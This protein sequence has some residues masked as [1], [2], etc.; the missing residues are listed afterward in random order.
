MPWLFS[1]RKILRPLAG[2]SE[3]FT[4][5][6]SHVVQLLKS[7]NLR[8]PDT[9]VSFDVVSLFTNAPVDEALQ[10]IRNKPHNG[11]TLAKPSVLQVEAIME[12]LKVCLRTTYFQVG[13]KFF[14][15]KDG[16]AMVSSLSPIISSIFMEH[17][18]KRTLDWAQ[19]EPSLWLQCVDDTFVIWPHG[20]ERL[21]ILL[22]HLIKGC[23]SSP[24]W[25]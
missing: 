24:V 21:Q 12:L 25:K 9:L 5:N 23:P 20:P 1:F 3:S 4:K 10:V 19:H 14:Q 13:G 17:F 2:K 15:Q 22:S 8:S 18:E 16:M 6:S 11:D 7:A